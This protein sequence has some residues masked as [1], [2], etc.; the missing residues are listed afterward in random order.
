MPPPNI[1]MLGKRAI[2]ARA[3]LSKI[4]R[5]SKIIFGKFDLELRPE[6]F[7]TAEIDQLQRTLFVVCTN[8]IQ[9]HQTFHGTAHTAFYEGC[10]RQF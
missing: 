3:V 9:H 8:I 2:H 6:I 4:H 7:L 10:L 5:R 1:S